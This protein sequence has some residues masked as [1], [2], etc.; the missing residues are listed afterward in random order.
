[1]EAT[2]QLLAVTASV[3]ASISLATWVLSNKI[4]AVKADVLREVAQLKLDLAV[5]KKSE[6][7]RDEKINRMWEWWMEAL[8]NGWSNHMRDQADKT[9]SRSGDQ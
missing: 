1:M 5:L 8:R 9:R 2:L 7:N 3:V 4:N 6:E